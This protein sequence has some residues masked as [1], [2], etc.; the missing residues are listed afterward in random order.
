MNKQQVIDKLHKHFID[1]G[2]IYPKWELNEIT[3][4]FLSIVSESLEQGHN[5]SLSRFGKFSV[6]TKKGHRF[7]NLPKG[8]TEFA[9][10]K[11]VI[12]FALRKRID[13]PKTQV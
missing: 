9:P 12:G 1:K 4:S 3:E 8:T 2:I 7:Y 13:S 5:V 11:R 6:K 10:E